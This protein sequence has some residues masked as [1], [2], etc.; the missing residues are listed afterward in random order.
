M[1]LLYVCPI[2]KFSILQLQHRELQAAD[3]KK[4]S[5]FIPN[6]FAPPIIYSWDHSAFFFSA[7]AVIPRIIVS[8]P[9][10]KPNHS[11][12]QRANSPIF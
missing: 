12:D 7:K 5:F 4:A 9:Q 2:N 1:I 10:L 6:E 11:A 8:K 3:E